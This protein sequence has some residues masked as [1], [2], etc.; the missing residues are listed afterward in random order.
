MWFNKAGEGIQQEGV[1]SGGL[2]LKGGGACQNLSLVGSG[3]FW[4]GTFSVEWCR[5]EK[6]RNRSFN[7][8]ETI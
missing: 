1:R 7:L 8:V 5:E 4:T 2:G 3:L 6:K